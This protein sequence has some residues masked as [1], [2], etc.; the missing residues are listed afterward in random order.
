MLNKYIRSTII[1]IVQFFL[2][3]VLLLLLTPQLL[4]FNQELHKAQNFFVSHKTGF[5]ITHLLFYL[6]L[7]GVWPLITNAYVK[8]SQHEISTEQVHSALNA[9]WYLLAA[10]IIFEFLAWWK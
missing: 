9:K 4:Q 6:A 8:R 7:L 5:L 10:M 1:I 3:G 2:P